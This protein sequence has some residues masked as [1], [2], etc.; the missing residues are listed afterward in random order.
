MPSP[1]P[2]AAP[3]VTHSHAVWPFGSA[4]STEHT[5][6]AHLFFSDIPVDGHSATPVSDGHRA[7][8]TFFPLGLLWL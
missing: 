1:L 4:L 8:S 7:V 5:I 2:T 3:R 6:K